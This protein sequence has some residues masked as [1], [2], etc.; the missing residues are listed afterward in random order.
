MSEHLLETETTI[1][2]SRQSVFGFFSDAV[3]PGATNAAVTR[4]SDPHAASDPHGG[5][6]PHRLQ[7]SCPRAADTL[8]HAVMPVEST[9]RVHR[10]AIEGPLSEMDS[11][12]YL[13]RNRLQDDVHEGSRAIRVPFAP[14]GDMAL[15]FVRAELR[16]IFDFRRKAILEIFSQ[17]RWTARPRLIEMVEPLADSFQEVVRTNASTLRCSRRAAT[18]N[19]S[20]IPGVWWIEYSEHLSARGEPSFGEAPRTPG[21]AVKEAHATRED[22]VE[23]T[24]TQIDLFELCD[25]K[26]G[27]P[28]CDVFR[29]PAC[30]SIDHFS[31]RSTPVKMAAPEAFAHQCRQRRRHARSR[32]RGPGHPAGCSS[33]PRPTAVAHS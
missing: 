23:A 2:A 26:L 20:F 19:V 6:N 5:G 22:L 32:S 31:E 10:R 13:R 33:G 30:R 21:I 12:P 18:S 17:I 9:V 24:V 27:L 3:E 4:V 28:G 8:A 25:N 1:P 11:P 16:G 7:N 14:F 29:I 15:P